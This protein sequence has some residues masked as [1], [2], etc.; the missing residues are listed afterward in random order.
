MNTGMQDTWNLAWK[1]ALVGTGRARASLLDSYTPERGAVG[2]LVL[3]NATLMTRVVTLRNPVAQF[4]RNRV[5]SALGHLPAFPRAF[6]KNLTELGIHYPHSPLN[7]ESSSVPWATGGLRPGDRVP[8]GTFRSPATGEERRLH[9]LLRGPQHDLLLLPDDPSHIA[10]LA[11]IGRRAEATYPGVIR[12]H[13]IASGATPGGASPDWLDP[14]GS[15][16][17]ILGA[18]GSALALVRPDGYLGYRC[19]P[20]SWDELRGYLDRYMIAASATSSA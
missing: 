4:L 11:E 19:Q 9:V 16:R 2:E 1:L 8:D 7:G 15:L 5:A 12:A 3:R 20:A 10:D 18:R 14:E 6:F 13:V 17:R